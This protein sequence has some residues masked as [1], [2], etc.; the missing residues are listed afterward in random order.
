MER[1]LFAG[2]YY[3]RGQLMDAVHHALIGKEACLEGIHP[4]TRFSANMILAAILYAMGDFRDA[5][6]VMAQTEVFIGEKAR[7]LYPNFKALQTQRV[8]RSDNKEAAQKQA[9]DWLAVYANSAQRLPFY[10]ICRH[11]TSLRS[12]IA[13]EDYKAAVDFGRRIQQLAADYKRPLDRIES[14]ILT[15]I[16]LW[17]KGDKYNA[18]SEMEQALLIAKPYGFIQLFINEGKEILPLLWMIRKKTDIDSQL[19]QLIDTLTHRISGFDEERKEP[20]QAP[21]LS[22]MRR[23]MLEYLNKGMSYNEIADET[24]IVRGTVKRHILLLYKQLGV[25]SGEEAVIKAKMLGL[26]E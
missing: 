15:A 22:V 13:L 8:I 7:F 19:A 14:T 11:F 6:N 17:E 2:I 5:G 9:Q 3:E 1:A 4:E 12:Y 26:L 16:A 21:H 20:E 25:N 24:G 10:Q 18:A 23:K